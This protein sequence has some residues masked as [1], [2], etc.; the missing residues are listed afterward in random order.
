MEI[1]LPPGITYLE[2]ETIWIA[3]IFSWPIFSFCFMGILVT[4]NG[5]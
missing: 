3:D 1:T 4:I 5:K 2:I